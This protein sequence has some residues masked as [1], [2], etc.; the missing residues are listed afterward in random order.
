MSCSPPSLLLLSLRKN[1]ASR[2]STQTPV[3]PIDA[4]ADW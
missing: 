3:P 1:T 4:A 2:D